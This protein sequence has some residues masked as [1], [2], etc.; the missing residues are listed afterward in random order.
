MAQQQYI[1]DLYENEEVS[2]REIA[3]RTKVSFQTVQKYAY[4]VQIPRCKSCAAMVY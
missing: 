3:R 1:K 4:A 2:L